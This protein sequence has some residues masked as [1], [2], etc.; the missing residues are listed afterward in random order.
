MQ[1]KEF[2]TRLLEQRT[3]GE[4]EHYE[5]PKA[6]YRDRPKGFKPARDGGWVPEPSFE[7]LIVN[8]VDEELT[9]LDGGWR[10][11]PLKEKA[12]A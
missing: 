3:K 7:T 11:T 9:A 6:L 12:P 10:L 2:E 4:H 5:Y 1:D 8:D